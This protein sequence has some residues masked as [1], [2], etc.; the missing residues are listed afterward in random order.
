MKSRVSYRIL[1]VILV[2]VLLTV[3][4]L[5]LLACGGTIEEVGGAVETYRENVISPGGDLIG[6]SKELEDSTYKRN[7]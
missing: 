4:M 3:Y 6:I 2:L 5:P 7:K 1:F